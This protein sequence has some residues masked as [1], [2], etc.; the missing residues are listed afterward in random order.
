MWE[1]HKK[2]MV[3]VLNE[4]II[5]LHGG[6]SVAVFV[7]ATSWRFDAHFCAS[8]RA[9]NRVDPKVWTAWV[10]NLASSSQRKQLLSTPLRHHWDTIENQCRT[11]P[12]VEY[13][14]CFL[15]VSLYYLYLI[16]LIFFV[17][18][19]RQAFRSISTD[20]QRP[21]LE[22]RNALGSWCDLAD[23]WYGMVHLPPCCRVV[24]LGTSGKW[25]MRANGKK[26]PKDQLVGTVFWSSWMT[27]EEK[28]QLTLLL[29]T[30][31]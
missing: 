7:G 13:D 22:Q 1:I 31:E 28:T 30:D 26:R 11:T 17:A 29:G 2:N 8:P 5:E 25:T 27:P 4:K 21:N 18:E 23:Q 24:R 19:K 16:V 12:S 10:E 6:F 20:G 15:T 14:L 3:F 9:G